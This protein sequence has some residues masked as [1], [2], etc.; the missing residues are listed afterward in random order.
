MSELNDKILSEFLELMKRVNAIEQTQQALSLKYESILETTNKVIQGCHDNINN[1]L[2]KQNDLVQST[3]DTLANQVN[4]ALH[5]T[6]ERAFEYVKSKF[7]NE[8]YE[9]RIENIELTSGKFNGMISVLAN[10]AASVKN[11]ENPILKESIDVLEL[12]VR[13][14]NCLR[15][16]EIKTIGD[17]VKLSERDLRRID[18]LGIRS[19]VEIRHSLERFGLKLI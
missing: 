8:D 16:Q 17:L 6:N 2:K 5:N 19:L 11:L 9:K 7:N 1:F 13:A 4:C 10:F 3:V 18:N 12:T 15:S 14:A